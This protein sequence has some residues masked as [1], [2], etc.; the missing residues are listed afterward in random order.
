L[1]KN[2]NINNK[3]M[4]LRNAKNFLSE[5]VEQVVKSQTAELNSKVENI[6][7]QRVT[8]LDEL[9]NVKAANA[10]LQETNKQLN[11]ELSAVKKELEERTK[12]YV[13]LVK[14]TDDGSPKSATK[15]EQKPAKSTTKSKPKEE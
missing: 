9:V 2:R 7:A 6:E 12:C 8:L 13:D 5:K 1:L 10:S 4:A 3:I 15:E 11:E 14:A